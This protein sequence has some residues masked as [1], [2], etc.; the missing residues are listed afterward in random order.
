MLFCIFEH[1]FAVKRNI[2]ENLESTRI[3]NLDEISI[4]EAEVDDRPKS[5]K[6]TPRPKKPE[7]PKPMIRTSTKKA[8]GTR[9]MSPSVITKPAAVQLDDS[10]LIRRPRRNVARKQLVISSYDDDGSDFDDSG[11][12]WE[13]HSESGNANILTDDDSDSDASIGSY[14]S[15]G[16]KRTA[17]KPRSKNRLTYLNLSEAEVIEVDGDNSGIAASE[18]DMANITRR[19][20]EADLE[21]SI[22]KPKKKGPRK[23]FDPYAYNMNRSV[24]ED[25]KDEDER[26]AARARSKAAKENEY[27]QPIKF[28]H[29]LFDGRSFGSPTVNKTPRSTAKEQPGRQPIST[30]KKNVEP[31]SAVCV[32]PYFLSKKP[33]TL[34]RSLDASLMPSQRPS[35]YR[36]FVDNF[37]SNR[38]ELT[39]TLFDMY[40]KQVFDGKL[41][42]PVEWNKKL[43]TTAGRF[44]GSSK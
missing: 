28:K 14:R 42:M 23:L 15:K 19:F 11:S 20:I 30:A 17:T 33:M 32:S 44:I 8:V 9:Q 43:L 31:K 6:K 41:E 1:L 39:R 35:E 2:S 25:H 22:D 21:D 4:I 3:G 24:E 36:K 38:E 34:V 29:K 26:K 27:N 40:N 5:T 37:K 10:S 7:T 16:S 18:E 12:D 13:K